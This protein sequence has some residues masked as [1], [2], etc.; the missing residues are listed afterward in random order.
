MNLGERCEV[1]LPRI[2]DYSGWQPDFA[3]GTIVTAILGKYLSTLSRVRPPRRPHYL[4]KLAGELYR[5]IASK[6]IS[7]LDR[8]DPKL[9]HKIDDLDS[10]CRTYTLELLDNVL[11]KEEDTS[12]LNDTFKGARF[13]CLHEIY[14]R[15]SPAH[16]VP[17]LSEKAKSEGAKRRARIDDYIAEVLAITGKLI[18]RTSIWRKAGYK[19]RTQFERWE[20]NSNATVTDC[21]RF[22]AILREKPH[23]K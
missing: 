3:L 23:M 21:Q 13:S 16:Q 19:T 8:V 17:A 9:I 11:M 10:W 2:T 12:T 7:L 1:D 4:S 14:G 20:R 15:P 5:A 18:N 6:P 22:E